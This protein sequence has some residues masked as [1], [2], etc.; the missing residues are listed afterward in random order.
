MIEVFVVYNNDKQIEK[1]RELN[2]SSLTFYFIDITT[3]K[4]KKQGWSIKN[5]FAAKLDPFAVIY[6]GEKPIKAFYTE[7]GDSMKELIQ[8]LNKLNYESE[9]M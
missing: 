6:K 9:E 2:N 7:A 4:G 1:V 8:F 3:R 5:K